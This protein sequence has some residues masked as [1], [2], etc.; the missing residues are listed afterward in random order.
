MRLDRRFVIYLIIALLVVLALIGVFWLGFWVGQM[1]G[2]ARTPPGVPPVERPG[3]FPPGLVPG[4]FRWHEPR[5]R[6]SVL[7]VVESVEGNVIV[8]TGRWGTQVKVLI[9]EDTVF[10]RGREDISLA[11]VQPGDRIA[12]LGWPKGEGEIEARVVW[13]FPEGTESWQGMEWHPTHRFGGGW[14]FEKDM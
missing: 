2:G 14:P 8:A 3:F 11:E 7:G 5:E 10:R 1:R 13:V 4:R 9:T 12:V 6:H